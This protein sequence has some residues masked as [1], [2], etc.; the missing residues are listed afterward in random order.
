M[1]VNTIYSHT[2]AILKHS[3]TGTYIFQYMMYQGCIVTLLYIA[4]GGKF[5]FSSEKRV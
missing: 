1:T 4:Q 3:N 2:N 5:P